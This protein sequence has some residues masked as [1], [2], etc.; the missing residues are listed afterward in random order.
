M[1]NDQNLLFPKKR[2]YGKVHKSDHKYLR[3]YHL[4]NDNEWEILETTLNWGVNCRNS[5]DWRLCNWLGWKSSTTKTI[6]NN[7]VKALKLPL[8]WGFYIGGAQ[9][10]NRGKLIELWASTDIGTDAY[11]R[12]FLWSLLWIE[13]RLHGKTYWSSV[14]CIKD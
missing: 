12:V 8:A 9:F 3:V 4:P 6:N 7:I 13:R 2:Q 1:T 14:R 10:A 5:T 11:T